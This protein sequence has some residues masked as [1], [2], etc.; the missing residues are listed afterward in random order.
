MNRTLTLI[1]AGMMVGGLTFGGSALATADPTALD[2]A[3]RTGLV[4]SR[5]EEKMA[6]DLYTK[7]GAKYDSVVWDRIAASEQRHFD[8]IGTLLNRYSVADPAS[9]KPAGSYNDPSIQRL[10]DDWLKRGLV[11][12]K[13]A[14]AVA[15][16]LE[17]RDI[18]DLQGEVKAADN[19]DIK[20]V[21]ASL[22]R[23][24]NNHLRAFKA[25]SVGGSPVNG[26]QDGGKANRNGPNAEERTCAGSGAGQGQGQRRG[27]GR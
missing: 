10:Y 15:I 21:Y 24:S 7:L 22:L 8:A 25:W 26:R 3:E 11:S 9:G 20:S 6:R 17:N 5:E 19:T 4:F 12:E 23:G 2:P 18:A 1:A 27:R 13:D 16:E 14:F